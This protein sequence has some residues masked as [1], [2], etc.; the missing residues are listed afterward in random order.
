MPYV[1]GTSEVLRRVFN[2][3]NINVCFKPHR[4]IRHI[5]VHPKDKAK[6]VRSVGQFITFSAVEG[7]ITTVR[8]ITSVKRKEHLKLVLWS[9]DD[10]AQQRQ[11][12]QNISMLTIQATKLIWTKSKY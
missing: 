8:T 10:P 2:K 9:T 6:K 11:K 4:T 1:K 5:L 3:H 7:T 12:C